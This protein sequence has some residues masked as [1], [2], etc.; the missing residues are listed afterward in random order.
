MKLWN[1]GLYNK[2]LLEQLINETR[3]Q[4]LWQV[5][6]EVVDEVQ[7]LVMELLL[8]EEGGVGK[9]EVVVL[10]GVKMLRLAGVESVVEV[11]VNIFCQGS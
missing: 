7:L 6:E 2:V 9:V 5:V 11:M 8:F 10:V 1:R 3:V 4:S